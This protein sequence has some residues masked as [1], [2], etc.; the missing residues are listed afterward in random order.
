M[1][2]TYQVYQQ[3]QHINCIV[4]SAVIKQDYHFISNINRHCSLLSLSILGASSQ[5]VSNNK[6]I[7]SR[8]I[9]LEKLFQNIIIALRENVVAAWFNTKFSWYS[10]EESVMMCKFTCRVAVYLMGCMGGW[11]WSDLFPFLGF[12]LSCNIPLAKPFKGYINEN[13][14]S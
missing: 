9:S 3:L 1:Y 4:S 11:A 2:K 5:E 8:I 13:S 12:G 10:H 6:L 14:P 7:K